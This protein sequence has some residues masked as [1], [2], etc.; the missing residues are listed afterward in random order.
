MNTRL[1]MFF[2]LKAITIPITTTTT[3]PTAWD[4]GGS[5]VEIPSRGWIVDML[6]PMERLCKDRAM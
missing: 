5:T 2:L 3:Y 4:R 1:V 6:G